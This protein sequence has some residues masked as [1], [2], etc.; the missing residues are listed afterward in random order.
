VPYFVGGSAVSIGALECVRD[1]VG[2]LL[3]LLLPV[4]EVRLILPRHHRGDR[5]AQVG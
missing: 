5:T 1:R 3:N 4:E 2:G